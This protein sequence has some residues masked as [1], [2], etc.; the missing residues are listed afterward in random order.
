[1]DKLEKN[2]L[3]PIKMLNIVQTNMVS[4]LLKLGFSPFL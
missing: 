4:Q 1:M 2:D 3:Y